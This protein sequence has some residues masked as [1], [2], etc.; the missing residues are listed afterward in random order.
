VG[1]A[2]R[3]VL[4]HDHGVH[5]MARAREIWHY[6]RLLWFFAAHAFQALYR[7]THLGWLWVPIR[8]LAPLAVGSLVYSSVM[9]IPSAGVPYFLMLL[10][11]AIAWGSFDGPWT[12]GSRGV[13]MHR[14]LVTKLYFPRM[15]LPLATMAP[16]LAEPGM[17]VA[18]LAVALPYYALADGSWYI[19][20]GPRLLAAPLI[21]AACVLF[22]FGLSLW[23]SLWQ[24]RA[25]DVRFGIGYLLGFWMYLTPV[26]YPM[27]QVPAR[28]RWLMW[29]NPMAPLVEA[30]KSAVFGWPGPPAWA[31][32]L[33]VGLIVVVV[34]GGFWYFH[35]H[36]AE[37]AEKI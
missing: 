22:A 28:Y 24:A 13:E 21:M 5:A 11:G 1:V 35:A 23:T 12:W 7:R 36:E 19:V 2:A 30:F 16:G 26:I 17:M 32:A 3:W 9:D 31:L 27:T 4:S 8:P 25:R 34:A 33:S 15:I 14:R 18:A 6:R 20:F 10:V 29:L 37:T